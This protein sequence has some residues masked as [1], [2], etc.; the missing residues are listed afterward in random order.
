MTRRSGSF[1]A[2][3][4]ASALLVVGSPARADGGGVVGRRNAGVLLRMGFDAGGD[5]LVKVRWSNGKRGSIKAGQLMTLAAGVLYRPDAPWALEG[6]IGYKLDKVNGSNGSIQ[7]T[8]IPLD[9]IVDW[10]HGGHRLGA[11][12][13]VHLAP[14]LSCDADGACD[15]VGDVTFDTAFGGI[16][17]YAYG[18]PVGLNGGFDV[19][20]RCTVIRYSGSGLRTADGTSA[21]FFFGGWL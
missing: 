11:G 16:L 4:A 12:P 2:L 10:A 19:G 5:E 1:A 15:G 9:L 6:T 7:F 20:V 17:Q 13:T 21:G 3:L 14:T 8:R 18:F